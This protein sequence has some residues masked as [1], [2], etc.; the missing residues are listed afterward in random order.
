[1]QS[2][3]ANDVAICVD[4]HE[5]DLIAPRASAD[6]RSSAAWYNSTTYA[7]ISS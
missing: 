3:T 2:R 4:Y 1:V 7:V 6:R 5:F